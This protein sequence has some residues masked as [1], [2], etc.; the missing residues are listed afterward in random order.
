MQYAWLRVPQSHA[1]IDKQQLTELAH[2]F[3]G[4]SYSRSQ[5]PL[6]PAPVVVPPLDAAYSL[7]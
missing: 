6:I 1:S 5:L 2:S 7:P 4:L 3:L